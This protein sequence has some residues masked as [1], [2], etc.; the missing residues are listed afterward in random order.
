MCGLLLQ[1]VFFFYCIQY[2]AV[3]YG[4]QEY[5]KWAEYMGL[6]I[7]FTSMMWVPVYAVYYLVTQ[8]GSIME[9]RDNFTD[10][11]CRLT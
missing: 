2:K 8:P 7:S 5:P 9:V 10:D 3:T 1:A 11:V 6:M 4:D